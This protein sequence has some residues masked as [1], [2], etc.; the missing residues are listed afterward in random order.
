M[1]KDENLALDIAKVSLLTASNADAIKELA[2]SVKALTEAMAREDNEIKKSIIKLSQTSSECEFRFQS[3]MEKMDVKRE[4]LSSL[5]NLVKTKA[6][7]DELRS[8]KTFIHKSLWW[9]FGGMVT[10]IGFLVTNYVLVK[11]P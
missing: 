9:L 10:V 3:M 2:L 6:S 5:E 7:K 4:K 1:P 11:H 8:V